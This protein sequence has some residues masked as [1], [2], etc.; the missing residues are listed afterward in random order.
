MSGL[1]WVQRSLL[2]FG[3]LCD[4]LW[5]MQSLTSEPA[6]FHEHPLTQ[7][8]RAQHSTHMSRLAESG[9]NEL[10]GMRLESCSEVA[11]VEGKSYKTS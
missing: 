11:A 4:S 8:H 7:V 9:Q 3:Q 1:V 10:R 5:Q 6:V 2:A